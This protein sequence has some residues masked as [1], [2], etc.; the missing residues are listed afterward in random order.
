MLFELPC[1]RTQTKNTN[2]YSLTNRQSILKLGLCFRKQN[3]ARKEAKSNSGVSLRC[4]QCKQALEWLIHTMNE[5]KTNNSNHNRISYYTS[6]FRIAKIHVYMYSLYV[7]SW[8]YFFFKEHHLKGQQ[9]MFWPFI[10]FVLNR[11]VPLVLKIFLDLFFCFLEEM[12]LYNSKF[13]YSNF[14]LVFK[15]V[16]LNRK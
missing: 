10:L 3:E 15:N 16:F 12:I 13:I 14:Y 6:G 1:T 8:I 4:F 7:Q 9:N 11:R 2:K 5:M